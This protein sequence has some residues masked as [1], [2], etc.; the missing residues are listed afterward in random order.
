M[1]DINIIRMAAYE[2]E[3]SCK[4]RIK[5]ELEYYIAH[6]AE[7]GAYKCKFTTKSWESQYASRK[8]VK[9]MLKDIGAEFTAA[10]YRFSSWTNIF[11]GVCHY[12]IS[13][14]GI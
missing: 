5:Q 8:K 10:G 9:Q 13:W 14:G 11:T 2:A 1:K 3:V 7:Y 6:Y 12:T 4:E